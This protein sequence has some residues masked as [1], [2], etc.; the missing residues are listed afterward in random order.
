MKPI[1]YQDHCSLQTKRLFVS[2]LKFY[3][4]IFQFGVK[5]LT[6][7]LP[8]Y[9]RYLIADLLSPYAVTNTITH[10]GYWNFE[11]LLVTLAKGS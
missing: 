10:H 2:P 6:T 8:S 1:K 3:L 7:S 9:R 4:T 11:V 5:Y